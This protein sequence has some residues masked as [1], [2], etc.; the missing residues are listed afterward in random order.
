MVQH[1]KVKRQFPALE[2]YKS[3]YLEVCGIQKMPDAVLP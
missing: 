1:G 3:Q 2:Y